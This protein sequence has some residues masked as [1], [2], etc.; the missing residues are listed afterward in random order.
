MRSASPTVTSLGTSPVFHKY[1]SDV[2][3]SSSS[4]DSS[5]ADALGFWCSFTGMGGAEVFGNPAAFKGDNVEISA[6]T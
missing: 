3:G 5:G 4:M 1:G 2:T 6:E